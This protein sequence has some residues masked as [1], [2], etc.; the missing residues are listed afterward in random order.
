MPIGSFAFNIVSFI[1]DSQRGSKDGQSASISTSHM[2]LQPDEKVDDSMKNNEKQTEKVKK[3][4]NI[5]SKLKTVSKE[6]VENKTKS[7]NETTKVEDKS[8]TS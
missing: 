2:A 8:K 3:E 5:E 1:S 4:K 7:K 6:T